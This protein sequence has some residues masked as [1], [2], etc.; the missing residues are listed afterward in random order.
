MKL[1]LSVLNKVNTFLQ[2]DTSCIPA[3]LANVAQEYKRRIS[4]SFVPITPADMAAKA[5]APPLYATKKLDG[6]LAVIF[7]D[8]ADTVVVGS[9]GTVR[10]AL[11]CTIE[12]GELLKKAKVGQAIIPAEL[13]LATPDERER[14]FQV[15]QALGVDG[16]TGKLCLA[17]F[18]IIEL[19]RVNTAA[20]GYGEVHATLEKLFGSA[21]LCKPV[22]MKKCASPQE[23]SAAF[24]EWV[25]NGG[26]EGVVLRSTL[27]IIYKVKPKHTIDAAIIGFTEGDG[28]NRGKLR[29]ILFALQHESGMFQVIGKT[30]NGFSEA[31]KAELFTLLNGMPA[32]S[33]YIETDSRNVA[34]R[35]VQPKLAVEIGFSDIL[36][37][38]ASGERKQNPMVT[39]GESG[40][41][42]SPPCKGISM[43][44]AVFERL[45][46]DKQVDA[47]DT[48]ISQLTRLVGEDAGDMATATNLPESTVLRRE[49]YT[50]GA[51]EKLMV[52]KYLVWKTNKESTDSRYPAYVLH[53]TDFSVGR[54]E[55]L[56]RELRV[57]SSEEQLLTICDGMIAENVKKGWEKVVL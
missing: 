15:K 13:Y 23:L 50:K 51:G 35:M 45:R 14:G 9:N 7:F 4:G 3:D 1:N 34:F 22:P 16:D 36:T 18:D 11:P 29:E 25:T 30:G 31:Q 20:D 49:V 19:D 57:S 17:P 44:H 8:G 53:Y 55:M 48:G 43:L 46:E 56:K 54:K 26:A 5:S 39:F 41:A 40:Y 2:G 38:S 32:D 27:P 28:D 6:E 21:S 42:P 12:A 47:S 33:G 37:E 24:E 52:Q 10:S